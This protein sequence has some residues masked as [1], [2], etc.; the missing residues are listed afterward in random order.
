MSDHQPDQTGALT[1]EE[2]AELEALRAE[3][4][5]ARAEYEAQRERE[6]LELLREQ[7]ARYQELRRAQEEAAQEP[8]TFVD[9][10]PRAEEHIASEVDPAELP[11]MSGLQRGIIAVAAVLIVVAAFYIAKVNGLF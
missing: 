11:P 8:E 7:H 4:E 1:D 2:R 9:E 10:G 3:K 6:E 5:A